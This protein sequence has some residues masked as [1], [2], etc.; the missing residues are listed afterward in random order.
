MKIFKMFSKNTNSNYYNSSEFYKKHPDL[1]PR[2]IC[3]IEN[4]LINFDDVDKYLDKIS[5]ETFTEKYTR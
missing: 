2:N 5:K 3:L 4:W 1:S